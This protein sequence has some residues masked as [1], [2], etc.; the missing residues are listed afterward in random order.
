MPEHEI[1]GKTV[2]KI[3]KV[4]NSF[5]VTLPR[6]F[7]NAHGLKLGDDLEL[8]FNDVVM[9]QPL[10]LEKVKKVLDR[11]DDEKRKASQT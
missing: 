4:G 8:F 3:V 2:R 11:G 5:G 10:D 1:L 6:K 7:L 9:I